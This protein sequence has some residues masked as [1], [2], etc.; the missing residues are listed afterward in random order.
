MAL[1]ALPFSID[2]CFSSPLLTLLSPLPPFARP[3][4]PPLAPATLLL[5]LPVSFTPKN[6]IL[7]AL[8]VCLYFLPQVMQATQ[9][10][11]NPQAVN[12]ILLDIL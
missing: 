8:T 6:V 3:C 2:H 5:P 4:H 9:G 7:P 10:K 1:T 12:A 11:A